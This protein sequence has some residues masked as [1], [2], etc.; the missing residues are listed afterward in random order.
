[1]KITEMAIP[2]AY[3]IRP[4]RIPDVRGNFYEAWRIS[5][6]SEAIGRPFPV[7]Q[8]NYSVS[9]RNTLRGI[10]STAVPPGQAKLITCVRGRVLDVVVDLRV[11]S[12]TFGM[13][14][15]T[16]QDEESGIAVY[17]ADGL[18]HAFLALTE[19]ACMNYVCAE[20]YVHGTMIDVQALD[21]ALGIPWK[22]TE[23]PIMSEK[24]RVAPTLDE[25]VAMGLLPTYQQCRDVRPS[26]DGGR[27]PSESK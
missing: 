7:M 3:R 10:H 13:Y 9:R 26:L 1:M 5:E 12:P 22:L 11:G 17:L 15:T 8:V 19:G 4:E 25:A 21:P 6:L 23:P 14:D 2:D 24:D 20:E 27:V 18:G 16:I